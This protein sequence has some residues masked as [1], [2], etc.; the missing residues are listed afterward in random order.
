MVRRLAPGVSWPTF[1]NWVRS[2]RG[3]EGPS[4]E[5]LLDRRVPEKPWQTPEAWVT[6]V[7]ALWFQKPQPSF[8]QIRE[9]LKRLFGPEAGL[10]DKT[11]RKILREAELWEERPCGGAQERVTELPGG[12]GLVLLAA[13]AAETGAVKAL[14]E[15]AQAA[16][17]KAETLAH[18]LLG[19]TAL[20]L[21]SE[22][23]GMEGLDGPMGGW[24]A[25][26][27]SYPY[28]AR[29]EEKTLAELKL[30][31][32]G[33][34]MWAAHATIPRPGGVRN[35]EAGQRT[36]VA[37]GRSRRSPRARRAGAADGSGC[38]VR[39]RED[40]ASVRRVRRP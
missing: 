35:G 22:R 19:V 28:K 1:L 25:A 4:W 16:A 5:R 12:G 29:T 2:W 27:S 32:A 7:K 37:V 26:L 20:P 9:T 38:G 13:A 15:A 34:A 36:A 39:Q 11:L 18:R 31:G 30:L 3:S 14:A 10:G 40:A 17:M 24:V 33:P 6:T 8:A 23:R 21:V